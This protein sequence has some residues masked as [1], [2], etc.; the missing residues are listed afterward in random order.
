[1][2]RSSVKTHS[3]RFG[4]NGE[5][6]Q[7]VCPKCGNEGF[8]INVWHS[9]EKD[10]SIDYTETPDDIPKIEL[11]NIQEYQ[12]FYL[13]GINLICPECG[14]AEEKK[15]DAFDEFEL[16][17][18]LKSFIEKYPRSLITETETEEKNE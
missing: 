13:T 9:Y 11:I 15:V 17:E 5:M 1:M 18:Y 7:L 3:R 12:E 8:Y 10:A 16:E 2:D 6:M 14:F 4:K